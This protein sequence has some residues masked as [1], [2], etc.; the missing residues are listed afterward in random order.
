MNFLILVEI[1]IQTEVVLIFRMRELQKSSKFQFKQ[2][3]KIV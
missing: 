3:W 1:Y 2:G